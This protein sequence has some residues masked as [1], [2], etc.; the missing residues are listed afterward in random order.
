MLDTLRPVSQIFVSSIQAT[1]SP[2]SVVVDWIRLTTV[3]TSTNGFPSQC[4][5]MYT[6]KQKDLPTNYAVVTLPLSAA[7]AL[8]HTE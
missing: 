2:V 3:W 1:V 6:G 7:N 8:L 5:V 4:L